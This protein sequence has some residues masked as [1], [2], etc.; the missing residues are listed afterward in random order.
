MYVGRS[1]E[2]LS[3]FAV[4]TQPPNLAGT[5]SRSPR[6]FFSSAWLSE[7]LTIWLIQGGS[8]NG[9]AQLFFSHWAF[10]T[11]LSKPLWMLYHY[12]AAFAI[13]NLWR[14]YS[15]MHLKLEFAL[16]LLQLFLQAGWAL[17]FFAFQESLLALVTLLFL[18]TT[19]VLAALLYGKRGEVVGTGSHPIFLLDFLY[20]GSE[21]GYLHVNPLRL[22]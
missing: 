6:S 12:L 4:Q 2:T 5:S 14:R 15:L 10:R 16:F 17:A 21:Y 1:S 11:A 7:W 19:T 3:S 13:W 20:N 18:C 8:E 22:S 9:G